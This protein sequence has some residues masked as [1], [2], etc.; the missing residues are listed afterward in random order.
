MAGGGLPI[1]MR[2]RAREEGF[3]LIELLVVVLILAALAALAIP[4]F[5]N[6]TG[7]ASDAQ[8]KNNLQ[9]AQRAMETYF[10]DHSSYATANMNNA[11][12][13]DSLITLE[14]TLKDYP[15]P[16]ISAQATSSYTIRV[17]SSSR[18][19]VTYRLRHRANGQTVRRCTPASTGG[20]SSAGTW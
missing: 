12:D 5:I 16:W 2:M 9:I 8:A 1:E 6:Q 10:L 15:T 18:T 7:K 20:C 13:P 3:T 19:P 14:S 17:T 11:P 4:S